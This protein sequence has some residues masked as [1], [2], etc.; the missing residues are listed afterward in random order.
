MEIM[1]ILS[2]E[3]EVQATRIVYGLNAGIIRW[4]EVASM[5]H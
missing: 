3:I 5:K 4:R 2:H 1:E